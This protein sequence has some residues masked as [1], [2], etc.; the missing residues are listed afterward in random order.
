MSIVEFI[1]KLMTPRLSKNTPRVVIQ[2]I[3]STTIHIESPITLPISDQAL[4]EYSS[5]DYMNVFDDEVNERM[6][7]IYTVLTEQCHI[8]PLHMKG[9]I[10]PVDDPT[11][12][13]HSQNIIIDCDIPAD[14]PI[15][16]IKDTLIQAF[17]EKYPM[18]Y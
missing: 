13:K 2:P 6:G 10:V 4:S 16:G 18:L 3:R 5:E 17:E 15:E 11:V 12:V 1:K 9:T 7:T 8:T 14:A